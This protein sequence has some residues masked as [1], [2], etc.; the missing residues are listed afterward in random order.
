MNRIFSEYIEKLYFHKWIIGICQDNIKDIIINKVFDPDIKWLLKNSS[1]KIHADPF[2]LCSKNGYTK[3]LLEEL[4][5]DGDYGRIFLITLDNNFNQTDYKILLDT[6]SHL[7]YPFVFKEQNRT[8]VF[9]EASKSGKLS[10]YEFDPVSES[11]SFLQDILELPLLDSTILKHND[12]YWIFGTLSENV[13][14]Y[15]L[16]VFFSDSLMGPYIQHPGNPVKIG[17]NGTRPAGNF[18]EVDGIIYRPIQNCQNEYGESIAIN[19]IT[20]LSEKNFTEEPY[21]P[22]EINRNNICN[23]GIH[24]IHTINVIDNIIVVDGK[25]RAFAPIQQFKNYLGKMS[26]LRN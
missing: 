4:K 19:K 16:Y 11:L 2:I 26:K 12:K 18:I 14:D 13:T 3:I 7:S 22:F 1:D 10:C 21:M 23:K 8:F 20:E 6:K 5:F 24:K 9:P 25:H 15:R 17:L